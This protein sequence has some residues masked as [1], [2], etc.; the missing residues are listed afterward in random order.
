[1]NKIL[2]TLATAFLAAGTAFAQFTPKLAG[3]SK[4]EAKP[5]AKFFRTAPMTSTIAPATNILGKRRTLADTELT[6][7]R[8]PKELSYQ[9]LG[10]EHEYA[11]IIPSGI[12]AS[13]ITNAGF[14]GWGGAIAIP[15]LELRRFGG[16]TISKIHV[17]S[18]L[19]TY[20][21]SKVFIAELNDSTG[22]FEPVWEKDVTIKSD[23][24]LSFDCD[25][26]IPKN[27]TKTLYIGWS[28][29]T[30]TVS[31][32]D[33][34]SNNSNY[35]VPMYGFYDNT[36]TSNGDIFVVTKNGASYYGANL[37]FYD[38]SNE[39]TPVSNDIWAETTGEGGLLKEDAC[40]YEVD[41]VRDFVGNDKNVNVVVANMGV[42][43]IRNFEYT[44]TT[45]SETRTYTKQINGG[46]LHLMNYAT[47]SL[48]IGAIPSTPGRATDYK[49]EITKVNG[50]ADNYTADEENEAGITTIALDKCYKRTPVFEEFTSTSCG[51]CPRGIIGLE[52]VADSLGED[53]V[54]TVSVHGNYSAQ[55]K[56]T[57]ESYSTYFS[58]YGSSLP[59]GYLNR[60]YQTDPY[61]D[62]VSSAKYVAAQPCEASASITNSKAN[63]ISKKVTVKSKFD[64]AIDIPAN[65]YA[66]EYIITE[67]GITG[68]GQLNYYTYYSVKYPETFE[69]VFG[70]NADFV[71]IS[72]WPYTTSDGM[73][74]SNITMNHVARYVQMAGT[75]ASSILPAVKAGES[76]TDETTIALPT[77]S[78]VSINIDNLKV[79]A[80]LVDGYTGK[81]VTGV[82][83]KVG[84]ANTRAD[85]TDKAS[86]IDEAS[87]NASTVA[88]ISAANGAFLV[89][90]DGATA[91]VFDANG[92]LV[93]SA[94]VQGE[95]SLPVFGS[96]VYVIRV[97][98]GTQSMTQKAIF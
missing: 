96:G 84:V 75:V 42:D 90:A 87:A 7:V 31:N 67:D 28:A 63:R 5:K 41:D 91:Q 49:L 15:V 16:N 62:I 59:M 66:V 21:D 8:N 92:R 80:V 3:A 72:Q 19:G 51:W 26:V 89:K 85:E 38:D 43:S 79:A 22:A 1:M 54:V 53:K 45:P 76:F 24:E 4:M 56:L 55:D 9:V 14:T 32:K 40:I 69:K 61:Y 68:V 30:V 65:T 23:R 17:H 88:E 86:G 48:P 70:S 44:V 78:S 93:S 46:V 18:Y 71:N 27:A 60:Q 50:V 74:Y 97:L 36:Q 34:Y 52:K 57:A 2:L 20:A 29:G 83:T 95:A 82:Q 13:T 81:I 25:Y 37:S 33:E 58:Q 64:F 6:T 12:T 73:P 98:K 77:N 94:T 11:Q 10:N 35:G 47:F 39:Y